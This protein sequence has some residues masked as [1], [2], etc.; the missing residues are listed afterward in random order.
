MGLRLFHIFQFK[1]QR[2]TDGVVQLEI[3][4]PNDSVVYHHMVASFGKALQRRR[5]IIALLCSREAQAQS[6][7]F[8]AM[9]HSQRAVC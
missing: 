8:G 9:Y 2:A 1:S 6:V 5:I 4:T 7:L 3:M